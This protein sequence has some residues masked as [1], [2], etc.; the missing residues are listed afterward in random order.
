MSFET[1]PELKNEL[2]HYKALKANY[3]KQ[4][5]DVAPQLAK[6]AADVAAS[7]RGRS[8]PAPAL[9]G[10]PS[11]AVALRQACTTA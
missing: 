8:P 11:T 6:W 2:A 7:R 10:H 3:R 1:L 4:V 5:A 9:P